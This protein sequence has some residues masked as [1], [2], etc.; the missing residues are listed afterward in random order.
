[1]A[2]WNLFSKTY[3]VKCRDGSEQCVFKDPNDAFPLHIGRFDLG[4]AGRIKT[5]L[6]QG[7]KLD[8]EIH[9]RADALLVEVHSRNSSLMAEFRAVYVVYKGDPCTHAEY[10][11]CE[12]ARLI[13]EQRKLRAFDTAMVHLARLAESNAV[14]DQQLAQQ[15][16]KVLDGIDPHRQQS[17]A[18]AQAID[19]ALKAAQ[20]MSE[21]NA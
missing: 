9:K 5:G 14:G 17:N 16:T 1:M 20:A 19:S 15:L 7:A 13:D 11:R 10:L 4:F 3:I 18:I 8:A 2:H 12:I 21:Q 6:M